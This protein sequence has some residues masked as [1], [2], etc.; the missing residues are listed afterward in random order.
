VTAFG[1]VVGR[2]SVPEGCKRLEQGQQVWTSAEAPQR[3]VMA[4]RLFNIEVGSWG[5]AHA[6]RGGVCHQEGACNMP[7]ISS[8]E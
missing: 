5:G 1:F 8:Y 3:A 6:V 2:H 7:G 4:Q